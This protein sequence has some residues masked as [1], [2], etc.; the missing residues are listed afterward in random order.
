MSIYLNEIANILKGKI[1]CI[2]NE[3]SE[4]FADESSFLKEDW[5]KNKIIESICADDGILSISLKDSAGNVSDD[6]WVRMHIE[7][8]GHEPNLFDGD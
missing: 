2:Y 8:T 4:T 1:T 3:K 6:S 5:P 7:K